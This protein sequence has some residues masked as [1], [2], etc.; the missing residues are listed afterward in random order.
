M[1]SSSTQW[2]QSGTHVTASVLIRGILSRDRIKP[3]FEPRRCA[4]YDGGNKPPQ[5]SSPVAP[6]MEHVGDHNQLPL[7]LFDGLL[8]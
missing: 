6:Y 7:F 4:I 3:L 5:P 2:Y 1:A 8:L